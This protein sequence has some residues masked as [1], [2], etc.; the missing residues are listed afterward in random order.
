MPFLTFIH[1]PLFRLYAFSAV[2]LSAAFVCLY[3]PT[4][5]CMSVYV[6]LCLPFVCMSDRINHMLVAHTCGQLS[7]VLALQDKSVRVVQVRVR[8]RVGACIRAWVGGCAFG[9]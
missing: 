3:A 5:A 8:V 1:M 9:V 6:C 2:P 7:A 4:C